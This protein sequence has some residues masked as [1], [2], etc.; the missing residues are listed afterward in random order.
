MG[1]LDFFRDIKDAIV[2]TVERVVD[3]FKDKLGGESYDNSSI[4]DQIDVDK[5]LSKFRDSIQG[6]I[7]QSEKKCMTT[8]DGMFSELKKK[9]KDRFPDLIEI[10]EEKQKQAEETLDGTVMQYVKEH[11]S[12]NDRRFVTVLEMKPGQAKKNALDDEAKKIIKKAEIYFYKKLKK[13]MEDIQKEFTDRLN[14]RLDDQEKQMKDYINKLEQMEARA[15]AGSL[16]VDEVI[17]EC[18]P[19]MESAEC[20]ITALE[21]KEE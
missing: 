6:D 18:A 12:K 15:K 14:A 20:I 16:N 7:N 13:Y 11:L 9:T 8:V 3:W 4:E 1:L 21:M 10:I 17:N 19:I 2:D 5:V